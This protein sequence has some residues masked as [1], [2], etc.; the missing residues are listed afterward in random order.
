MVLH[1]Y[2]Q[3]ETVAFLMHTVS[4][5]LLQDEKFYLV[6]YLVNQLSLSK[7]KLTLLNFAKEKSDVHV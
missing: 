4:L 2:D 1:P 3:N 5:P 6:E 7:V